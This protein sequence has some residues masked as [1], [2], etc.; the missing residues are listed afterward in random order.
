ME[1]SASIQQ[2]NVNNG[3]ASEILNPKELYQHDPLLVLLKDKLHLKNFWIILGAITLLV[4]YNFGLRMLVSYGPP[5]S[6]MIKTFFRLL[7]ICTYILFYLVY[8]SL[9]NTI[10]DLFNTLRTNRIVGE[11][12][13]SQAVTTTYKGFLRKLIAWENSIWWLVGILPFAAL[14]FL[15][16]FIVREPE[17]AHVRLSLVPPFW[18]Q[19]ANVIL[20]LSIAYTALFS[21]VRLVVTIAFANWMF[22]LFVIS[23]KPLHPDGAGG[24]GIMRLIVWNSAGIMLAAAMAFFEA[25]WLVPSSVDE[26]L[27]TVAYIVLVPALLLGWLALPHHVMVKARDTALQPLV[28][29]FQQVLVERVPTASDNAKIIDEST[30]RLSS[31]KRRYEFLREVFPTWPLEIREIRRLIAALSLPALIPLV[32]PYLTSL[33]SFVNKY[34]QPK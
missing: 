18:L 22:R 12:L 7:D 26:A 33:F 34:I 19:I 1:A 27:L 8:L 11:P 2:E 24:L 16:R 3:L 23:V 13:R 29:E 31:L 10:A 20:D 21:I 9:P 30:D 28:D 15:Y 32:L 25:D 5:A 14:Y 4:G 6:P 17:L